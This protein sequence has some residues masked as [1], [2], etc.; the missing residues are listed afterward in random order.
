[1]QSARLSQGLGFG[2]F[3]IVVSFHYRHMSEPSLLVHVHTSEKFLLNIQTFVY[4]IVYNFLRQVT[5][6]TQNS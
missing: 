6:L 5:W 4:L 1:M 2:S 3:A